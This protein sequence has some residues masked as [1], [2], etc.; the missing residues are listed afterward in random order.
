M[1][2]AGAGPQGPA[3][4]IAVDGATGVG[5]TTLASKLSARLGGALALDPFDRNPFLT[6][7]CHGTPAQRAAVA[8]PM[9][10]AFLALRVG[11]LRGIARHLRQADSVVADW[12]LIKS[13]VFAALTLGAADV[14]LFGRTVDVWAGDLPVPDLVVHLRADSRTLAARVRGRGRGIE[15]DLVPN[16]ITLI[17]SM[18][19]NGCPQPGYPAWDL[20]RLNIVAC[21]L[22]LDAKLTSAELITHRIPFTSAETAY[23]LIDARPGD[24]IKVVLTHAA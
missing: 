17:S 13:R 16:R 2:Q 19:V 22:V 7:Y 5:K 12:A 14:D 6:E 18:T 9:E 1:K 11:A 3:V 24:T 8:L 4:Y 23:Q 10:M 21:R 20:H 15:K